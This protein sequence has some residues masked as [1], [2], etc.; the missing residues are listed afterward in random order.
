[1]GGFFGG[2]GDEAPPINFTPYEPIDATKS[3]PPINFMRIF[4]NVSQQEFV[5]KK[6]PKGERYLQLKNL[7]EQK[8]DEYNRGV[9]NPTWYGNRKGYDTNLQNEI[10]SL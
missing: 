7:I 5:F 6:S 9:S 3:N 1:M 2:D 10:S 8:K 4:D